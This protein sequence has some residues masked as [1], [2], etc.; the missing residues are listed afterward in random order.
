LLRGSQRNQVVNPKGL[1]NRERESFGT[2]LGRDRTG[3]RSR[4][5][6]RELS[7]TETLP[8]VVAR[9]AEKTKRRELSL[10]AFGVNWFVGGNSAD[11][12]SSPKGTFFVTILRF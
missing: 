4:A 6:N 9:T 1:L 5:T 11:G 7:Q 12:K 10:S 8:Q 2:D 3:Q